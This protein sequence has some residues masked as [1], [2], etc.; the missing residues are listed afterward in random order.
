MLIHQKGGPWWNVMVTALIPISSSL[1]NN[2]DFVQVKLLEL[3]V[4]MANSTPKS[5]IRAYG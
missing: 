4:C 3:T 1:D 5:R 2:P